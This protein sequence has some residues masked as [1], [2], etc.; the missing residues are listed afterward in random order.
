M[1]Y[2]YTQKIE[3]GVPMKI[4]FKSFKTAEEVERVFQAQLTIGASTPD[5]VFS[6]LDEL[7]LYHSKLVDMKKYYRTLPDFP[8]DYVIAGHAPARPTMLILANKWMI[9]FYF[10]EDKKLVKI[11][12]EKTSD[13]I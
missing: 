4:N 10:G 3:K 8:H 1:K 9:H 5:D 11:K 2:N 7:G 12:A 6:I 13:G